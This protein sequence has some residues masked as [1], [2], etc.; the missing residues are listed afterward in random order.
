[1]EK[2]KAGEGQKNC[3]VCGK[4][5]IEFCGGCYVTYYCSYQHQEVHWPKH[6]STCRACGVCGKMTL[7]VCGRCKSTRYCSQEHQKLAWPTHK[8]TCKKRKWLSEYDYDDDDE[9]S[10]EDD[11]DDDNDEG[12]SSLLGAAPG[13]IS[14]WS[15]GLT[16]EKQYEWLV[17]CYRM[18]YYNNSRNNAA[19]PNLTT[20]QRNNETQSLSTP[21]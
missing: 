8:L 21:L 16:K 10:D 20:A 13:T 14:N 1:M 18:R 5:A 9:Y 2:G 3:G 6:K 7:N 17:D 15:K 11:D 19:S 12:G 4:P